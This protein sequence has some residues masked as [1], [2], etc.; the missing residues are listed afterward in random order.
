M[1]E[2]REL[3]GKGGRAKY[4]ASTQLYVVNLMAAATGGCGWANCRL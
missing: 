2:V 1:E 4:W 3:M